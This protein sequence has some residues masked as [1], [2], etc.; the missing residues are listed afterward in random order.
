MIVKEIKT[1]HTPERILRVTGS[2][3]EDSFRAN[4]YEGQSYIVLVGDN[5]SVKRVGRF[6]SGIAKLFIPEF[7][8]SSVDETVI[9][10][11]D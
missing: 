9:G 1:G 2:N 6:R 10:L 11:P 5:V 8:L 4:D 7:T 3:S